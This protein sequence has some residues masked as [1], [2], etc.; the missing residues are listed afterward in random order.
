MSSRPK[1]SAGLT[2]T[3]GETKL[4]WRDLTFPQAISRALNELREASSRKEIAPLFDGRDGRSVA[5]TTVSRWV[6]EPTRFPA[7][8]LPVI[9]ARHEPFQAHVFRY[10]GAQMIAP[11][12]ILKK[13]SPSAAK[14]Y[15][16]A[17]EEQMR[18][19][20]FGPGGAGEYYA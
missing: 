6:G 4:P 5:E 8:C 15:Q 2:V 11:P 12:E 20:A 9:V 13:L 19:M 16:K 1:T 14:E 3:S 18:R 17:L 7:H 10:L